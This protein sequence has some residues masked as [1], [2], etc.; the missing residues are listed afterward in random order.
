MNNYFEIFA[1]AEEY[2]IDIK[3]LE[4][5]YIDLQQKYHPDKFAHAGATEKLEVAN[6]SVII[7]EAYSVLSDNMKRAAYLLKLHEIDINKIKLDQELLMKILERREELNNCYDLDE[8]KQMKYETAIIKDN[9]LKELNG[10]FVEY[11]WQD[12]AVSYIKL[13]YLEK[14][15]LELNKKEKYLR[16]AI[17]SSL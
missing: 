6:F 7:N 13:N 5:K 3:N 8:L 9:L 16:N 11:N 12:A 15:I 2:G 1:I 17:H 10:S 14:Y 4:S